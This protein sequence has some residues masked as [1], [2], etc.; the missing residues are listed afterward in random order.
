MP[1]RAV[2]Q[3]NELFVNAEL[4]GREAWPY[5]PHIDGVAALCGEPNSAFLELLRCSSPDRLVGEERF[6]FW[7]KPTLMNTLFDN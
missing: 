2:A 7:R 4:T 5:K 6:D 3:K 1:L